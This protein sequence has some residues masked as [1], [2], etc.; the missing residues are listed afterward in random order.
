MEEVETGTQTSSKGELGKLFSHK[1]NQTKNTRDIYVQTGELINDLPNGNNIQAVLEPLT[2]IPAY[3][4][5]LVSIRELVYKIAKY[6]SSNI[7]RE[8]TI[9]KFTI[10][11]MVCLEFYRIL[12]GSLLLSFVPQKC[13]NHVCGITENLDSNGAYYITYVLNLMTLISFSLLYLVEIKRENQLITYLDVNNNKP[14]DAISVAIIISALSDIDRENIIYI[15]KIYKQI[16]YCVIGVYVFNT[17]LS[18]TVIYANYLD[19]KTITAF[20]TNVLFMGYKIR[21]VYIVVNTENNIFFSA[22]LQNKVQYND[23][24]YCKIDN[25][26]IGQRFD[27]RIF[28]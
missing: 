3:K 26:E 13:G 6:V 9:Q 18:G 19:N 28:T 4:Y 27:T 11:I 1:N 12:M 2:T 10:F 24:D 22:Y 7:N 17:I 23:V 15:D 25:R 16:G 21:Q 20:F 14:I 5:R 8:N